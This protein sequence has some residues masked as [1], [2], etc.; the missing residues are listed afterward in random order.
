MVQNL[1]FVG[2]LS[3]LGRYNCNKLEAI[4]VNIW[5]R[6][7]YILNKSKVSQNGTEILFFIHCS[8]LYI[9]SPPD[10]LYFLAC[11]NQLLCFILTVNIYSMFS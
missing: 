11:L 1:T 8:Y 3:L 4:N 7:T 5:I 6:M 9:C 10:I 2:V